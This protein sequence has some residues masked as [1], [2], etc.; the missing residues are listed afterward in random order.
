MRRTGLE[1]ACLA[2]LAPQASVSTNSTIA[3][4]RKQEVLYQN[5]EKSQ[6]GESKIYNLILRS[7]SYK[8]IGI[9]L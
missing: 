5:K 3:A 6:D 4:G 9:F 2:A 1:P 7:A 8:T